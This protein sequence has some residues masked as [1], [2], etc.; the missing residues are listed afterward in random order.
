MEVS[1]NK[2]DETVMKLLHF[3]I[4]EKGYSPIV[5]HGAKNEVWLE[6]LNGN[7][8]I[9]RIV[10]DYI[11]NDE[12]FD[13]D[14]FKTQKIVKKIKQKT[15]S[16]NVNT[17]SIYLNL[18]DNV[19][20]D[21]YLHVGNVDCVKINKVND[22]FK[23]DYVKESFPDLL[24]NTKF[25]EKGVELFLKLTQ[26]ISEKNE[27][28][29]KKAED[30]FSIKKPIIT[31]LLICICVVLFLLMY[32]F[33]NGS[34]DV[35]T[36]LKFGANYAPF[37][38]SGEIFRLVSSCFVHIGVIHIVFNMYALYIV[39]PQIENFYGKVKF[40]AIYLLSAVAGSLMSMIFVR[41]MISA[42]ASGA[43]FGLFGSLLYFGYHYRIYLGNI[44]R[45]Q[46]IPLLVFNVLLGFLISGVDVSSHIGGLIAGVLSSMA[47][48]VKYKSSK[49]DKINGWVLLIIF[50]IFIG[51]LAFNV[52]F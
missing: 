26:D 27:T 33:G 1:I 18:G 3:F 20:F 11:H 23:Y 43:I 35:N 52:K 12:Q 8:E 48:G 2:E 42:G 24:K 32:I 9:V 46:V 31:Y 36:L 38:R 5:L 49:A 4:T 44:M 50:F 6:N 16:L 30:V 37:I 39:G 51:F 15:L 22:L 21:K 7:Y 14:I 10:S 34:K 13:F 17:L 47:L 19:N 41:D 45:S 25:K 29:S 28:E 40:L